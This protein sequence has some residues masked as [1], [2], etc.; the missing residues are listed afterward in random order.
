M[1]P[2]CRF[3][4]VF[5]SVWMLL[6]SIPAQHVFGQPD[7]QTVK[8]ASPGESAGFAPVWLAHDQGVFARHQLAV[9][10]ITTIKPVSVLLSGEAKFVLSSGNPPI[11][12]GVAGADVLILM[13]IVNSST[14]SILVSQKIQKPKDLL[15][16]TVGVS[17]IGA[18]TDMQ[19]RRSLR[20]WGLKPERDLSI[21]TTGG[22]HES[23]LAL[24]HSR[25][26]AAV[27]DLFYGALGKIK[28]GFRE[29]EGVEGFKD[30]PSSISSQK[31]IIQFE[32]ETVRR[33]VASCIEG[34]EI[35]K[36]RKEMAMEAMGRRLNSPDRQ[37]LE[38]VYDRLRSRMAVIPYP[39]L[40]A[41]R[42]ILTELGERN[43]KARQVKPE[44]LVDSSFV[45]EMMEKGRSPEMR[46]QM[47]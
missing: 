20:A 34:I 44:E 41:V 30:L 39:D 15:G 18:A 1:I 11:A 35:F 8:V 47:R 9:E 7:L 33:F 31:K 21:I 6:V 25:V 19:L 13:G 14:F 40:D 23:L 12:A 5:W 43:P 45:K 46:R 32:A 37:I 16:T 38:A 26:D 29:M 42:A 3:G 27:V 36:T 24:R 4:R 17:T 22:Q 28:F 2:S 10:F